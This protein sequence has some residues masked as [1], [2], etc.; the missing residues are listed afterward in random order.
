MAVGYDDDA[1]YSYEDDAPELQDE[2][3]LEDYMNDEEYELMCDMFPRAKEALTEYQGWDNFKVKLAIFDHE[4]NLDE[5]LIELKRGLKKKKS[6]EPPSKMSALEQLARRRALAFKKSS[7]AASNSPDK[8]SLLSTQQ[9]KTEEQ[10]SKLSLAARLTSLQSKREPRRSENTLK[11]NSSGSL[12][13]RLSKTRNSPQETPETAANSRLS[14]YSKLSALRKTK[15]EGSPPRKTASPDLLPIPPKAEKPRNISG[16]SKAVSFEDLGEAFNLQAQTEHSR[17]EENMNNL[18]ISKIVTKRDPQE[19]AAV[20]RLKRKHDEIHSTYYPGTNNQAAKKHASANFQRQS[21]DDVVLEA[22]KRAFEDVAKVS[23]GVEAITLE[24]TTPAI[25]EAD[26]TDKENDRPTANEPVVRIYKKATVP[27]KP[28]SPIDLDTFLNHKKPHLSFVVIG[29]VDA[30]KSTLMGRL[31]YDVGAVDNKLIRKL[32]RESEMIGKSSFHLAWVMDQTAEERNRGVTVDICTSDFETKDSTFTIVDAPGHRD[33]VPNAIAGVSQVD[34][35]VLSIDCSTGAFESGFN[36]DGQTKEHTILARSLG[37]R[38][39]IVA[40]NKMDSVDWY[41]GRFLDIKFELTNFFEDMGVKSE[42]V[43]WIPCSGLSGEGVFDKEYPIGQTWYKGPTLVQRLEQI[44]QSL[45]NNEHREIV[46]K[47]FLF[48]TFDVTPGSKPNEATLFGR[49]ES[50]H[51]QAG[52]TVTVYPSEQSVLITQVLAGNNQAPAAAAMKG[53]FVTLKVRNA[54]AEDINKGDLVA[55]VGYD[56]KSAQEFT[57]QVLTFNLDRPLLPGTPLMFF[58]GSNE[59]PARVKRLISLVDKADPSKV[60]KKKI[61]HLG[62]NQLAIIEIELIEKK[63]RIPMLTIS[64]NKQLGRIVLRKEG[65]TVAA[66]VVKTL[67]L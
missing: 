5:A 35:A 21:P 11:V 66:G 34:V 37:V 22:Q 42:Q 38:H 20:S 7:V 13:D 18:E 1:D 26:E 49:V 23:K 52:E 58:R 24:N 65:R 9:Q 2:A 41:E 14:L 29:H 61:R 46:E 43:S 30:G 59:Q 45:Y 48:S 67:D 51:I 54:F 3:A 63:R 10:P 19:E 53:D 47:P 28:K 40:M 57:A 4:F 27:T 60:I 6:E 39:I 12:I 64:E 55:V 31:L 56:I 50:G 15:D 33:F 25:D 17:S 44:S 32:K 8:V 36:L 16:E 62:S